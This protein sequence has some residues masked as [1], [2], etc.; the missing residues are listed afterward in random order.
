MEENGEFSYFRISG[1]TRDHLFRLLLELNVESPS[2]AIQQFDYGLDTFIGRREAQR[3]S[4][5]GTLADLNRKLK[6][7]LEATLTNL[8]AISA[9]PIGESLTKSA[10]EQVGLRAIVAATIQ[11]DEFTIDGL[12]ENGNPAQTKLISPYL[13]FDDEDIDEHLLPPTH[14]NIDLP[15][16]V[17]KYR[18]WAID[19]PDASEEE[20]QS[21]YIESMLHGL[22]YSDLRNVE[23]LSRTIGKRLTEGI[24]Y[25]LQ[26]LNSQ[27]YI[28]LVARNVRKGR[29]P[30]HAGHLFIRRILLAIRTENPD[31]KLVSTT[32]GPLFSI[33]KLLFD[34]AQVYLTDEGLR[35]KIDNVLKK[36][37]PLKRANY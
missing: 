18:Q 4:P 37:N 10:L 34:E 9:D 25:F 11:H 24:E 17:S 2:I 35:A 28:N 14:P 29:R 12:D 22:S 6:E 26:E 36:L 19:N 21:A 23:R 5:P 16:Q 27:T 31:V 7:S 8:A 33:C 30:D 3:S 15:E 32:N 13:A 20:E 1:S